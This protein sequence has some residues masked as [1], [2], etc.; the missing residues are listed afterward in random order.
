MSARAGK[1]AVDIRLRP[2]TFRSFRAEQG[3][4]FPNDVSQAARRPPYRAPGRA[5]MKFTRCAAGLPA[6]ATAACCRPALAQRALGLDV[7]AH[8]G[9]ISQTQWNNLLAVDNR[10]F[11]F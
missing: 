4:A 5:E 10:Q 9:Q 1:Q 3:I 7:S 11:V 6:L 8:Q 2:V